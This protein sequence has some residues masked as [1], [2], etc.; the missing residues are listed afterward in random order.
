MTPACLGFE[1]F[2]FYMFY[3]FQN[4]QFLIYCSQFKCLDTILFDMNVVNFSDIPWLNYSLTICPNAIF[5]RRFWTFR[6]FKSNILLIS[7]IWR[8]S[9]WY[10]K[11]LFQFENH[12]VVIASLYVWLFRLISLGSPVFIG[13]IR[14]IQMTRR[15]WL[16][17]RLV[18]RNWKYI[19]RY[20]VFNKK[21]GQQV[22]YTL[23]IL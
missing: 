3:K 4:K 22:Y 2:I 20:T 12:F 10:Y 15:K 18:S 19:L 17:R 23:I 6:F 13:L 5:S 7:G 9:H 11:T 16:C 1:F 21:K 14:D 8:Y